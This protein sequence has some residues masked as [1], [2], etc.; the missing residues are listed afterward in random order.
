MHFAIKKP[1]TQSRLKALFRVILILPILI[2][3]HILTNTSPNDLIHLEP[4]KISISFN[5][6][7]EHT[8]SMTHYFTHVQSV[9]QHSAI[10]H[11][12]QN[13]LN[14]LAH[15]YKISPANLFNIFS[16]IITVALLITLLFGKYP[17]WWFNW[18]VEVTRFIMRITAY[19]MLLTDQYPSIDKRQDM[20]L[21]IPQPKK[22]LSRGLV[23]I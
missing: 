7:Q 19:A 1:I 3:G 5:A 20:T 18:N 6:I 14:T 16:G 22:D 21:S 13:T 23:L 8:H 2:L 4:H 11:I 12:I 17:K 15:I 9:V 10:P